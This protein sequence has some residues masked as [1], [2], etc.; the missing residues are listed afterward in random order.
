M[1]A[2]IN[3]DPIL[4]RMLAAKVTFLEDGVLNATRIDIGERIFGKGAAG[5]GL[6][7]KST[8]KG[9]RALADRVHAH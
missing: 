2:T 3:S 5:R 9:S 6:Q 7:G 8:P 4:S 1:M